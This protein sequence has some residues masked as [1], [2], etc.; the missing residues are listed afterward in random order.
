MVSSYLERPL[1][2]MA[3]VLEA[4]ARPAGASGPD[5]VELLVRLLT[6]NTNQDGAPE[7]PA[8]ASRQSSLD[9]RRA[10]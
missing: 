3:Q 1:R 7:A 6:E 9:R 5:S 4:R 8:P 10:A 2:T